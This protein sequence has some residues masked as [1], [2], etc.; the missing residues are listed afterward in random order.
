MRVNS[1]SVGHKDPLQSKTPD[2]IFYFC[3]FDSIVCWFFRFLFCADTTPES[4]LT[5]GGYFVEVFLGGLFF[6]AGLRLV[7]YLD[8]SFFKGSRFLV[9]PLK[10]IPRV[11]LLKT[12]PDLNPLVLCC[13][14]WHKP[15][16]CIFACRV[17]C[18][19]CSR[20]YCS[21]FSFSESSSS[22]ILWCWVCGVLLFWG[23]S[24]VKDYNHLTW[25]EWFI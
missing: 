4:N 12:K 14:Y 1:L 5:R 19:T 13:A 21:V 6:L 15:F 10:A 23:R 8:R 22:P 24:E 9:L 3:D 17:L 25:V 7:F 11:F 16:V 2:I 20:S 18:V